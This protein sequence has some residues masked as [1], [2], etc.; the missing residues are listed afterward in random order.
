MLKYYPAQVVYNGMGFPRSPGAIVVSDQLIVATGSPEEMLAMYPQA[1]VQEA[2]WVVAPRAINAHTHLDMSQLPFHQAPYTEWITWVIG[3]NN[4]RTLAAAQEGAKQ[5]G[6]IAGF[7]DIVTEEPVM[8]YLLSQIDHAGIAF[9][10]VVAPNPADADRVFAETVE[11]I[12]R[13]QQLE[14]PEGMRVGISPHSAHTVSSVLLRK[15]AIFAQREQIPLQIHIAESGAEIELFAHG[16]GPLAELLSRFVPIAKILG[17]EPSPELTPIQ[18]LAQLGVL[19]A[20]PQ[21]VHAVH[22]TEADVQ[23]IRQAG[24]LVINCTRSNQALGC[25]D[26]PWSLYQ[27]YGVSVALGSDSIASG[28]SL[29]IYQH[30]RHMLNTVPKFNLRE[31]VYSAVKGGYRSIGAKVP[32]LRRGD[33]LSAM[34]IWET[35]EL[36]NS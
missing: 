10:E 15:L 19:A 30:I 9:W 1:E 22:V 17:R 5:L 26:F 2:V 16:R 4:Q 23:Q 32:T 12:R 6:A 29:D 34:H 14:R 31:A 18:Y 33:P 24:C 36:N 28:G 11:R 8:E 3:H 21:L 20:Q 13:F 35:T 27:Q 7:N 25:G